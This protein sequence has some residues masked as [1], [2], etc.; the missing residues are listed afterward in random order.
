[1]LNQAEEEF[2]Y[3]HPIG[4]L[5]IPCKKNEFL[6]VTCHFNDMKICPEAIFFYCKDFL[7]CTEVETCFLNENATQDIV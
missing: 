2:G 4:G 6:T 3:E 7:F 5:T 1:M